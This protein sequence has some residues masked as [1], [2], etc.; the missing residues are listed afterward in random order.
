M[1]VPARDTRCGAPGA[2]SRIEIAADRGPF[3]VGLKL[4]PIVHVAPTGTLTPQVP[5]SIKSAEFAPV[6]V[7]FVIVMVAAPVFVRLMVLG[8][9]VVPT[10]CLAYV[11]P[12]AESWQA[13]RPGCEAPT[14]VESSRVLE[15]VVIRQNRIGARDR[16]GN[17]PKPIA[18]CCCHKGPR[19]VVEIESRA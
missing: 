13:E 4:A 7:R 12:G 11:R 3:K 14:H 15:V 9:L 2:L 1:P 19:R 17:W 18:P 16:Q 5:F 10:N 6:S 8:W